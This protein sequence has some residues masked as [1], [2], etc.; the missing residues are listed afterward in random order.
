[1]TAVPPGAEERS[2]AWKISAAASRN[3]LLQEEKKRGRGER[4]GERGEEGKTFRT[5][6]ISF[7]PF[8]FGLLL[9]LPVN[10]PLEAQTSA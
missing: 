4:K 2:P 8:P 6:A 3:S 9:A 1:M 5:T 7:L 10:S